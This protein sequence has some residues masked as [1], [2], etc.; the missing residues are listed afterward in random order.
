MT[1]TWF[2]VVRIFSK[3]IAFFLIVIFILFFVVYWYRYDK[4]I[5]FIQKNVHVE[6]NFWSDNN[7]VIFDAK[8]IIPDNKKVSL[9][10]IDSGCYD[11]EIWELTDTICLNNGISST[12]SF[13]TMWKVINILEL[14]NSCDLLIYYP[15]SDNCLWNNCFSD[16][17]KNVFSYNNISFIQTG[18]E[19]Y[20]CNKYFGGCKKLSDFEWDIICANQKWLIFYDNKLKIL[21]LR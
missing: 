9:F 10:N 4:Q 1:N 15:F 14:P 19:L 3:I 16:K 6:F 18:K 2:I 7:F 13:L 21:P 12:I 17:I 20:Y 5:W 8:K 11:F